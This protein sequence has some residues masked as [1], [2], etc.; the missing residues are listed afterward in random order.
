[1]GA[2]K[3]FQNT[4]FMNDH[5]IE[6]NLK[7]S[8]KLFSHDFEIK[9]FEFVGGKNSFWHKI[10]YGKYIARY[11]KNKYDFGSHI[12]SVTTH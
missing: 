5:S 10:F 7:T 8:N 11:G 6:I 2:P 3:Y 9:L 12:N 1:M 4:G